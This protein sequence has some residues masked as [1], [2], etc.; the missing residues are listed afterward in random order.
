MLIADLGI[1]STRDGLRPLSRRQTALAKDREESAIARRYASHA[2]AHG[3]FNC[4]IEWRSFDDG[5][6]DPWARK[7]TLDSDLRACPGGSVEEIS[8]SRRKQNS[9]GIGWKGQRI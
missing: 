4:S 9:G 3:R 1:Q 5:W 2:E 7:P 8:R 6:C